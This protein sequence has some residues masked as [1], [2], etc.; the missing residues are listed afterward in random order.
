METW[1]QPPV[2]CLIW[3]DLRGRC[4]SGADYKDLKVTSELE[5]RHLGKSM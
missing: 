5:L 3:E 4:G 1:L 2:L